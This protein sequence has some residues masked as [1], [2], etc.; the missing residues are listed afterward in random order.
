[1]GI[2]W[3]CIL[4]PEGQNIIATPRSSVVV[5]P[6]LLCQLSFNFFLFNCFFCMPRC[7]QP[8]WGLGGCPHEQVL[9]RGKGPCSMFHLLAECSTGFSATKISA[10][11]RCAPKGAWPNSFCPVGTG[12]SS[13]PAFILPAVG[14][15]RFV[16]CKLQQ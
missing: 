14:A 10:A 5:F 7:P 4:Q 6:P 11:P 16:S 15:P 13:L 2:H 8:S 1:M 12:C 9:G 3:N